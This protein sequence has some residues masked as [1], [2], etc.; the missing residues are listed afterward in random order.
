MGMSTVAC[1]VVASFLS[2]F[3]GFATAGAA[4]TYPSKPIRLITSSPP[5][6]PPDVAARAYSERLALR[7]GQPIVVDNR[8]GAIGTI[9]LHAVAKA[10]PD[11][12][13]L[14]VLSISQVLAPAL[15][16]KMPYDIVRDLAPI[17][18]VTWASHI[19]V[20]RASGPWKTVNDLIGHAKAKPGEVTFASGG[21]ATPAHIS[22]ELLKQRTGI[23]IRHIPYK[24]AIAG[25]A[26]LLAEDADLM[27]AATTAS[28]PHIRTG[29]LRAL[30]TPAPQRVTGYPEV[31]TMI[32][33]GFTGFDIREW[34]G[35]VAPMKAPREI[36]TK[37]ADELAAIA[38]GSDIK[39]QLAVHALE[40]V[41][42]KPH[43]F[44]DL[45][46]SEL[47]RWSVVARTAG[48]RAD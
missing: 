38:S 27:F 20:V 14:G 16:P 32:E 2:H 15:L 44:G 21:N 28:G 25:I 47:S 30:A 24:G 36:I 43:A 29:K 41:A 13:T 19:L 26:A 6:S 10:P 12:Y 34:H 9:A 40:P 31:P 1:V 39:A 46:R 7:I 45:I 17:A 3:S 33:L 35:I 23:D 11:G 37:L 8:P 4:P 42:G 18:Q 22:G 48:L 5:G